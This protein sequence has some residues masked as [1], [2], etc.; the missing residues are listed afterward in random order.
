MIGGYQFFLKNNL[1]HNDKDKE[2]E[3]N[4][5]IDL[6]H[7]APEFFN[8]TR[9]NIT[10]LKENQKYNLTNIHY[11][12]DVL[13]KN[14]IDNFA[15]TR[16][17]KIWFNNRYYISST[18]FL[19][20]LSN[21]FLRNSYEMN[22]DEF[23]TTGIYTIKHSMVGQKSQTRR[24]FDHMLTSGIVSLGVLFSITMMTAGNVKLL[25]NE[26]ILLINDL[27][28]CT[29]TGRVVYWLSYFTFDYII[30][31]IGTGIIIVLCYIFDADFLVYNWNCF[32]SVTT[33]LLLFGLN[34]ILSIYI[35]QHLYSEPV[36]GYISTGLSSF[37]L[38]AA[39]Q[40]IYICIVSYSSYSTKFG[41]IERI[42]LYLF[43]LCPQFNV[44]L[45]IFKSLLYSFTMQKLS[46]SLENEDNLNINDIISQ[47]SLYEWNQ[48]TVHIVMLS[49]TFVIRIPLLYLVDR[50]WDAVPF[51]KKIRSIYLKC[52]FKNLLSSKDIIHPT[53]L[54]EKEIVEGIDLNDETSNYGVVCN[55]VSK[56]YGFNKLAVKDM[57][58]CALKGECLGFLGTNGAGKSTTF[59]ILTKTIQED[60]GIT[61]AFGTYGYCPQIHSLNMN[62]TPKNQIKM[63][64]LLRGISKKD[65]DIV[66]NWIL[67]QM[68]LTE[69]ADKLTTEL[70][71][72]NKRKLSTG[73]AIIGNPNIIY[74]DEPTSGMD[75]KSQTFIWNVIDK[76]RELNKT[77]IMCSHSM[78]E[79]E[80]VC[81]K[82]CIMVDGKIKI[83]GSM[84]TLRNE[85]G[86]QYKLRV[87][88]KDNCKEKICK[89]IEEY[90]PTISNPLIQYNSITYMLK[91]EKN[92][93]Q[94]MLT[95]I[96]ELKEKKLIIDHNYRPVNLDDI[97]SVVADGCEA[98]GR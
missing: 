49:I 48:I 55:N 82:I 74:L 43:A 83:I 12:F 7:F 80:I 85:L 56:F 8:L 27:I 17:G 23:N 22:G 61:K 40:V 57:S 62:I 84:Q 60:F 42:C 41:V 32:S 77:I 1:S 13:V 19:N 18:A 50:G 98:Q 16:N 28:R 36:K 39:F 34:Y 10:Y 58:L 24:D 69:H 67:E 21:A 2:T 72:G 26:R 94:E 81:Q 86:Y 45:T 70:S 95:T 44:N 64:G 79:C 30:F 33:V 76:L 91:F 6:K 73:I 71:G 90:L 9:I 63:Y 96:E 5:Y 31:V 89:I 15:V 29:G 38:G 46:D 88:A 54:K 51:L 92:I 25:I 93:Y 37:F 87:K 59:S 65:I 47:P 20:T 75:P 4:G 66:V 53:V 35:T 68:S 78:D 3:M 52:F 97:F 11:S 14:Y